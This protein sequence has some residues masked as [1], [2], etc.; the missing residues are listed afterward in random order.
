MGLT[1]ENVCGLIIRSR[2]Q[3]VDVV[4]QTYH[5]WQ[6]QAADKDDLDAFCTWLID[7]GFLTRYQVTR[8][9]QGQADGFFIGPYRIVDRIDADAG[10]QAFRALGPNDTKAVI[11]LLTIDETVI[12]QIPQCQSDLVAD[13]SRLAWR[14]ATTTENV[15]QRLANRFFAN[16]VQAPIR[17]LTAEKTNQARVTEL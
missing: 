2:L 12:V 10:G 15:G 1:V 17:L 8:I 3:P 11:H 9:A 13:A 5:R 4:Q 14:Q 16:Q 7:Q 6:T